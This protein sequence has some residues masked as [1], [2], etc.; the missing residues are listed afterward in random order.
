LGESPA[1]PLSIRENSINSWLK[2]VFRKGDSPPGAHRN[3]ATGLARQ[4]ATPPLK[5]DSDIHHSVEPS[6]RGFLIHTD[7]LGP[8]GR[9]N[10]FWIRKNDLFKYLKK[11]TMQNSF[12]VSTVWK[13]KILKNI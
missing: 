9:N 10:P 8:F 5:N 6:R 1:K 2:N 4:R 11:I 3:A 12:W 7:S 13:E